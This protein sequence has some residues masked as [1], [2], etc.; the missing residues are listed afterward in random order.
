VQ[1][2]K[3]ADSGPYTGLTQQQI[4]EQLEQMEAAMGK[5]ISGNL[6]KEIIKDMLEQAAINRG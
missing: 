6:R 5:P 2:G 3:I 4:D 1:A